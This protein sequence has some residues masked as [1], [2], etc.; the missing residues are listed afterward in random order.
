MVDGYFDQGYIVISTKF[1]ALIL[2]LSCTGTP[3]SGKPEKV[4]FPTTL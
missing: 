4:D 3:K 2:H 1:G